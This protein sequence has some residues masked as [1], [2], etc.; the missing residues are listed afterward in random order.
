MKKFETKEGLVVPINRANI[1]TDAILPK[2][3]LKMIEKTGFGPFLF[4][5]WRYLDR[6][7]AYQDCSQRPLNLEFPLNQ[8]RFEGAKILLVR[9]NFGCGSSREHAPWALVDW[10]ITVIIAP[11]FAEIFYGNCFKNSLLPIV[12]SSEDVEALFELVELNP[13]YRLGV[14]LEAQEV[15]LPSGEVKKFD[16]DPFR[17]NCLLQGLDDVG[18]TLKSRDQI[19]AFE[20]ERRSLEPW[21][22]SRGFAPS[23][24]GAEQ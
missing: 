7:E 3:F 16:V 23:I 20:Q 8:P 2:Q 14:D 22:F 6:G 17:K 10:G 19:Q 18:I 5:D 15:K 24:E 12:L 4:D 13:G 11:S 1:D 9:E 21:I